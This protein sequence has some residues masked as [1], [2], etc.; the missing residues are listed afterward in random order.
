MSSTPVQFE[1]V[2]HYEPLSPPDAADLLHRVYCTLLDSELLERLTQPETPD[3]IP[4]T[5]S[6][7]GTP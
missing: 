1:L 3:T 5:D 7:G 6:L 4:S 2:R